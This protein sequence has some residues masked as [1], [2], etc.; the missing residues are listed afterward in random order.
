M[1]EKALSTSD[2]LQY[3]DGGARLYRGRGD[4]AAELQIPGMGLKVIV[5]PHVF[6]ALIDE[7]KIKAAGGLATGYYVRA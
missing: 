7:A 1:K 2:I 6:D 4:S 3:M 5:P